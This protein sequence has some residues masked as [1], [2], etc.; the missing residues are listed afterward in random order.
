MD[1]SWFKAQQKRAGVTSADIAA[2]IGRD[3][4]TVSHIYNGRQ[5]LN[6]D[7][8]KAFAQAFDTSVEE[9]LKHAGQLE[10]PDVYFEFQDPAPANGISFSD[11]DVYRVHNDQSARND[12]L[13]IVAAALYPGKTAEIWRINSDA[14]ALAGLMPGDFILVDPM[15]SELTRAGDIVLA[16][17][18]D[19]KRGTQKVLRR[20]EPPVLVSASTDPK[21]QRAMVVDHNNVVIRGKVVATWRMPPNQLRLEVKSTQRAHT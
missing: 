21:H 10:G 7:W 9:V 16:D 1:T 19:P 6:L 13:G 11:G 4:S 18:H 20:L 5:R 12:Q 17:S 3:R 8:A 14:M 15:L 2:L